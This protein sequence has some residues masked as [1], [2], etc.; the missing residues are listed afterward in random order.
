MA[1]VLLYNIF[2]DVP[3]KLGAANLLILAVAVTVPDLATLWR[4]FILNREG[5]FA[6]RWAPQG[7]GY[8]GSFG[9]LAGELLF[10][11]CALIQFVPA[12][13]QTYSTA[14]AK[15]RHPSFLTGEWHVDSVIRQEQGKKISEPVLTGLGKPMTEITIEPSGIVMARAADGMLWRAQAEIDLQRQTL[16][17][18][19]GYFNA[20]RFAATYAVTSLD[21]THLV[22]TPIGDAAN[23]NGV[24]TLSRIPLP[25]RYP[26]LEQRFHWVNEWAMER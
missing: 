1:N 13:A 25:V 7:G 23:T 6:S 19:S 4:I 17:L 9:I 21:F 26:L 20:D 2:F 24:M 22:L 12:F 18:D 16:T 11:S 14:Q 15:T 8:V 10:V 3:V 5:R